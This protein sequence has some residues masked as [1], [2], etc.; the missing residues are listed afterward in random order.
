M[1]DAA[2]GGTRP[3]RLAGKTAIVTG[4]SEGIAEAIARVLAREGASVGVVSRDIARCKRVTA[5]IEAAGGTALALQADVTQTA[6]VQA[7]V[8]SVLDKWGSVDILVNGVGGFVG[9]APIDEITEEQWDSVM[10]LNMK[11]AFLCAQSVVRPM[12]KK[13]GGRIINIGSIA[14]NGPNPHSDSFLP[15][16]AAKAGVIG[17]TKHLAKQLG[18]YGITVNAVSPG[19]TIT[20]RVKKNRDAAALERTKSQNALRALVECDDTANAVLYL[21]SDE[22]RH[23]T[24]VNLNVNAGGQIV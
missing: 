12:K 13:G 4:A 17:F 16:G 1:A 18:P 24:G 5:D 15:Y 8:Q 23:V 11:T 7:M 21:A 22:A 6:Q 19:T 3:G 14:A 20:E 10:T 2:E 9:K